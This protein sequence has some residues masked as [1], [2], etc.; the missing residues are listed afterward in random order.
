MFHIFTFLSDKKAKTMA[1]R[2]FNER[3]NLPL[4]WTQYY[5]CRDRTHVASAQ[6]CESQAATA[7]YLGRS[8]LHSVASSRDRTKLDIVMRHRSTPWVKK[9]SLLRHNFGKY[10]P[11]LKILS[12]MDS[13]RNLQQKLL[14]YFPPHFK[15]YLSKLKFS[16]YAI[17]W[18]QLSQNCYRNQIFYWV[19]E[20]IFCGLPWLPF[21]VPVNVKERES[22]CTSA[23]ATHALDFQQVADDVR[24]WVKVAANVAD[25]IIYN[26]FPISWICSP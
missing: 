10:W 23:P 11:I 8:I 1:V 16:N 4:G 14:L 17:F 6:Q 26:S 13:A 19:N 15:H 25:I 24:R 9:E 3:C 12:L 2:R 20:F 21:P 5:S 18:S 7:G 22:D